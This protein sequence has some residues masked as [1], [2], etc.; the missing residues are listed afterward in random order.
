MSARLLVAYD[1]ST[2]AEAAVATAGRLFAGSRGRLLTIVDVPP[3]V[4]GVRAMGFP[5]D[6][7]MVE[8]G[9]EELSREMLDA[10]REVAARGVAAAENAALTLAPLA[11]ARE[12]GTWQDILASAGDMDADVIVCGSRGRGG[13]ARSLLG[14]TS[15]G[16][17]HHATCPVLVVPGAPAGADD[18]ALIAYDG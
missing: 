10:G 16:V 1:G 14:S 4:A 7:Q 13:V 3:G 12:A 6:P 8:Q 15:T 5:L 18:P 11:A 2:A 17:V 9:I